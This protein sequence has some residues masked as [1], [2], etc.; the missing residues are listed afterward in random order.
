MPDNKENIRPAKWLFPLTVEYNKR[1]VCE[2]EDP[3]YHIDVTNRMVSC[4]D[5][6]A[7]LDPFDVLLSIAQDWDNLLAQEKQVRAMML[8]AQEKTEAEKAS[9]FRIKTVNAI[10]KNYKKGYHP[11]CPACSQPFDPSEVED[12]I[13]KTKLHFK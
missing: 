8:A 1:K 7:I 9:L 4:S 2:C 3:Q 5:C 13:H 12:Y 6:G 11:V 10:A